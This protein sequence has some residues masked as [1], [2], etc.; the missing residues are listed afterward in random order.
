M[1]NWTWLPVNDAIRASAQ[2]ALSNCTVQYDDEGGLER[3]Y[4]SFF[5]ESSSRGYRRGRRY[6]SHTLS[7]GPVPLVNVT[8]T[9]TNTTPAFTFSIPL[10]ST[11][12]LRTHPSSSATHWRA[13][14]MLSSYYAQ[15]KVHRTRRQR[16]SANPI[17]RGKLLKGLQIAQGRQKECN[18]VLYNIPCKIAQ[19]PFPNHIAKLD[20][21]Q[22]NRHDCAQAA[23][24]QAAS[25][26][27][28]DHSATWLGIDMSF[29]PLPYMSTLLLTFAS[30]DNTYLYAATGIYV[31]R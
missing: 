15:L 30:G 11:P 9:A 27:A 31:T 13:H 12:Y 7:T 18:W 20:A 28:Q 22:F 29:D 19:V 23:L 17:I 5:E 3:A 2:D 16:C 6:S 24:A 26:L 8:F 10:N 4:N 1:A 14:Q 25:T 21:T